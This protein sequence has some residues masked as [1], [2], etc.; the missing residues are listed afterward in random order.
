MFSRTLT[1]RSPVD[2]NTERKVNTLVAM[3]I[4]RGNSYSLCQV[5]DD[6]IILFCN[7]AN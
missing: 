7:A 5:C 1:E 4:N 2:L 6:M 3:V